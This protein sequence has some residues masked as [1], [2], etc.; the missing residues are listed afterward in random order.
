MLP[1]L[2]EIA[3][4]GGC[5]YAL[6]YAATHYGPLARRLQQTRNRKR[7]ERSAENICPIHGVHEPGDMVRLPSGELICPQCYE[8]VVR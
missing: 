1:I 3:V 5:L 6:G 7:I 2:A 8:E 4:L